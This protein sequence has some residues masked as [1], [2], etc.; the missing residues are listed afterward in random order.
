V[1]TTSS[2]LLPVGAANL[3][4]KMAPWCEFLVVA[5]K[6]GKAQFWANRGLSVQAATIFLIIAAKEIIHP[7][8]G[9]AFSQ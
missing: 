1:R 8:V 6:E 9:V 4:T 2:G 3:E 5:V 7:L